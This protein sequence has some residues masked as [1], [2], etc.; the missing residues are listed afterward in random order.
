MKTIN[1]IGLVGLLMLVMTG[2]AQGADYPITVADHGY[3]KLVLTSP[4]V[5]V[6]TL[7]N[8]D[9]GYKEVDPDYWTVRSVYSASVGSPASR[10]LGP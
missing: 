2:S 8:H 4:N 7:S 5:A 10:C 1:R 6:F 3:Y 9:S